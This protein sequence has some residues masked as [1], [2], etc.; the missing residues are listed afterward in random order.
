M[1]ITILGGGI[2]GE[3]IARGLI[4]SGYKVI[5]AEKRIERI[6][7]L[8]N[9]G[10]RVTG[11]NKAAVKQ[12]DVII[13]C[14]KPKD[15]KETLKE[16]SEEIKSKIL[17]SI[18]AAVPINFLKKIVSGAK[19]IRAMPNL[20]VLVREAFIAYS[21]ESDVNEEDLR[22][23]EK[24]LN[25]LGRT[26]RVNEEQMDALTALNGCAPAYISLVA[27]AMMYAGLEIG[28]ER[29]LALAIVAQAMIGT[30][31]L[32]LEGEKTPSEICA[33]VTTPGGV[34]IEG[35]FELESFPVRHAFMKAIKIAAEKT[36]KISLSFDQQNS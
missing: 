17:I 23:V 3:A 7:E 21:A 33:M 26:A 4:S 19:I 10:L 30:G 22:V 25:A 35:L 16:V 24:I 34:T 13:L 28:I 32:I 1:L 29:D 31:K 12:A 14:V 11:D 20:A 9:M 27:E 15:V 18:A 6:H 36:H 8:E 5:V 2:L